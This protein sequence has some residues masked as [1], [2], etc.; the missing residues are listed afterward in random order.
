MIA[1]AASG[2]ALDHLALAVPDIDT[3][4]DRLRAELGAVIISGDEVPGYRFAMTRVGDAERGMNLE[5]LEPWQSEADDF[6]ERFVR[7]RGAA[8][9]HITFLQPDVRTTADALAA[10]GYRLVRT[11]FDFGPW[12]ETFIHPEHGCGTVIQLAASTVPAPPMAELLDAAAAG[13]RPPPVPFDERSQNP[14][15]WAQ[16]HPPA[17]RG[18]RPAVL[19]R[20]AV[21]VADLGLVRELFLG[22]LGGELCSESPT[23]IEVAWGT[24]GRIRFARASEP[25]VRALELSGLAREFDLG[26][27]R[28]RRSPRHV[29]RTID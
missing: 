7:R 18:A 12:Q 26:S 16:R 19:E 13:R 6:L 21:E 17:P 1:A 11:K 24:T 20:V 4:L 28:F 10:R 29:S 9:H 2:V 15:W 5:L 25:G 27:A 8:P 22:A 14:F 3:A 23:S